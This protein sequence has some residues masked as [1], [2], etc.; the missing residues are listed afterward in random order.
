MTK[1]DKNWPPTLAEIL[2]R[3]LERRRLVPIF[4]PLPPPP[5][6]EST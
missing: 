4:R 1:P 6:D 3:Q 2:Q 5:E